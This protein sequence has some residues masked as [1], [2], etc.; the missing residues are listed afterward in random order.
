[1]QGQAVHEA[2][3]FRVEEQIV[4]LV[5][6]LVGFV[7]LTMISFLTLGKAVCN[8]YPWEMQ[9][10]IYWFFSPAIAVVVVV[11]VLGWYSAYS[12]GYVTISHDTGFRIGGE[13]VTRD[14]TYFAE[15]QPIPFLGRLL[16]L[17]ALGV[18]ILHGFVWTC[19]MEFID[20][21][22][23]LSVTCS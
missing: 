21:P 9:G 13:K 11:L 2:H 4:A 16:V 12:S 14:E 7:L 20:W 3:R 23:V 17:Y 18:L 6:P 1:M 10:D 19:R 15:G 5:A 8:P 22:S